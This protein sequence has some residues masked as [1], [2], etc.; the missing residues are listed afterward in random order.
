MAMKLIFFIL[1]ISVQ[2]WATEGVVV[3]LEAPLFKV[4]D[5]KSKIIQYHRKGDKV[6][7]HSQN[8]YLPIND[9]V[10]K[11]PGQIKETQAFG[12]ASDYYKTIS[13]DGNEAYILKKHV[14][15]YFED[16]REFS[17]QENDY[18]PTD[19]RLEEPLSEHYPFYHKT[20]YR[21]QVQL[22]FGNPN[23]SS[24]PFKSELI[25][26][27]PTLTKEI[28][29]LY[30]K[31]PK[32]LESQRF[33]FGVQVGIHLSA[34][35]YLLND[36]K[37]Q[38]ENLR[39][40]VGPIGLYDIYKDKKNGL[41]SF[42]GFQYHLLDQMKITMSDEDKDQ[43]RYFSQLGFHFNT[44]LNYQRIKAVGPVDFISGLYAQWHLPHRYNSLSKGSNETYWQSNGND[45][46]TQDARAE[47]LAFL[48]LQISY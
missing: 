28:N 2:T 13:R 48:G 17:Y 29:F 5:K 8:T 36:Y 1:L 24:Y 41:T 27:E 15:I 25:D 32:D 22:A 26:T 46:Y 44:G 20:G 9:D 21:G 6:Y 18:D 4:P 38:Q 45:D 30:L 23:Y 31:K 16:N 35:N 7:I 47:A 43:R 39:I 19:Y 14:R 37:A 42:I 12:A 10:Y 3:V 40:S 34:I 33:Y 11:L